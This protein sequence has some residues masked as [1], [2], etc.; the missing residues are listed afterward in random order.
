MRC[1]ERKRWGE[2]RERESEGG[3]MAGRRVC[4]YRWGGERQRSCGGKRVKFWREKAVT[5]VVS[6]T[7]II[8]E[9][10]REREK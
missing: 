7:T 4:M 2:V 10:E 3:F 1:L 5:G 8:R 6:T 9:R